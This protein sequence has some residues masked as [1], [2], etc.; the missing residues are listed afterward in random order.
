MPAQA[1]DSYRHFLLQNTSSAKSYT[2]HVPKGGARVTLPELDRAQHGGALQAQLQELKP[3]AAT[4]KER[5]QEIGLEAGL[6]IQIQFLSR[7]DADL[8]FEKLASEA[9]HKGIEL[10]SIQE[11]DGKA[12]LA[13]VFVPDGQLQHFEQL[14]VAYLNEKKTVKGVARDNKKLLDTINSIR[15]SALQGLWTDSPEL[16][17]SDQNE[18]F[19]WEVWLRH[20][21]GDVD[22]YLNDFKRIAAKAECQVS[23]AVVVFPERSVVVMYGSQSQLAQ[24]VMLLNCVAELR[25]AKDTAEFFVGLSVIEQR[26][27]ARDLIARLQLPQGTDDVP[28]VCLLDSGVNR[29]HPLLEQLMT[30]ADQHTVNAAWGIHDSANHGTGLAGIVAYGDLHQYLASSGPVEIGHRLESVKLTPNQGANPGD[31]KHHAG[32]FV[33]AVTLPETYFGQRK[34]VFTSAVTASDYRDYGRPSAWSSVVDA[35]AADALGEGAFPRLFVLSAGNI[36]DRNHW[37]QYPESL[38]VNQIHDPGQAWNALTVGAFTAKDILTEPN[39]TSFKAIAPIG[40]LSPFTTTSS[41]WTG[42]AWPLKPDVVFEGGNAATDGIVVDTFASLELLTTNNRPLTKLFWTTNATSAASALCAR[43]AAQIM[44]DYPQLKPET[45]RALIVNS[46]EW[47]EAM[48]QQFPAQGVKRTKQE[49]LSLIQHCGWGVPDLKRALWSVGNSLSLV[50]EDQ[51]NPYEKDGSVI[52]T[53]EMN[54]HSLPWPQEQLE[55]LQNTPVEMRVTLSYF[56]EPN[57]SAR[58]MASKYHYPSHRLR[59]AVRRSLESVENFQ[60]RINAATVREEEGRVATPTDSDWLLG[61]GLRHRGSLHQD[62]WRGTATDLASRGFIAVYPAN[63]WWRTRQA[64]ERYGMPARYSL[65]VSILTPET[66]VDLYTPIAQQ[67]SVPI[68]VST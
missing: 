63:G 19:W 43:M 5:Q 50:I 12:V 44:A 36:H 14:I 40:A 33:D 58:G 6:G 48:L 35:L 56:I 60:A 55:A 34:R 47:T 57:P 2:A 46:A 9:K 8:A 22:H 61:D 65:I 16:L 7:P 42:K 26:Q 37:A 11:V 20:A 15:A 32:L 53:R 28:R 4:A 30:H 24:S 29:A 23:D 17:P 54:F 52:K 67:V 13:N 27:W 21:K 18:P 31:D 51:L 38:A 59:F 66:G 39:T 45:I 41:Q 25:R 68:E 10:L 49:N 62:I 3:L 1:N 64:Q